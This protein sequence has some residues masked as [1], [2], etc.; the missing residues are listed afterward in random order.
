MKRAVSIMHSIAEMRGAIFSSK[1]QTLKRLIAEGLKKFP[2]DLIADQWMSNHWH[3][4]LSP[5]LDGGMSAFIGW[6]TLTHTQRYHAHHGT[7]GYG[8]VYQGRYK[9][10]PVQDDDHFHT[11]C[12]YMERNA[13]TVNLVR[14]AEDYRW[15]SLSNWLGGESPIELATWPIR[16]LPRWVARVNEAFSE[17][18]LKALR[19]SVTRSVPYGDEDWTKTTVKRLA[20]NQRP[21]LAA[22]QRNLPGLSKRSLTPLI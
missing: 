1:T 14:R 8:H 13:L 20:W 12:R 4:V 5:Q 15:G 2:V 22:G 17:K 9:S 3:M 10:F 7:V 11:V 19:H 6:V 16:R 21:D 18:E